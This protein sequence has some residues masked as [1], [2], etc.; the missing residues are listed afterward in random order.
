M[1]KKPKPATAGERTLSRELYQEA[2]DIGAARH[3]RHAIKGTKHHYQRLRSAADRENDAMAAA[4]EATVAAYF[5]MD[6]VRDTKGPDAGADVGGVIGV[7]WTPKPNGGLFIQPKD[8]DDIPQVLVVGWKYP[9]RIVGWFWPSEARRPEFWR[10]NIRNPT[11]IVPQE[12]LRS[13]DSLIGSIQ[14]FNERNA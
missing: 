12:S 4:A 13:M 1:P 7:R 14:N 3:E 2:Y 8:R 11:H 10:T 6:W 5:G 9:L